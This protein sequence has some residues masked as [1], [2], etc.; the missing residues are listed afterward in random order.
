MNKKGLSEVV[1]TVLIILLVLAAVIIIWTAVKP[2]LE[3]GIKQV[4]STECFNLDLTATKCTNVNVTTGYNVTINRGAADM[5]IQSLVF[6]SETVS[7][8]KV[9][10]EKTTS[11][12]GVLGAQTYNLNRTNLSKVAITARITTEDGSAVLCEPIGTPVVCS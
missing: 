6:N 8:D 9:T 2:M 1:T 11:I 10:D 12:L 7:G 3:K 4:G 5:K